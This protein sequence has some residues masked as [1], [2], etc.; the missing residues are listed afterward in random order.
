MGACN[1]TSTPDELQMEK[2]YK[3]ITISSIV[4]VQANL[5]IIV[6]KEG[7]EKDEERKTKRQ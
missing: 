1:E 4:I 7:H 5:E 3:D 2:E 6:W